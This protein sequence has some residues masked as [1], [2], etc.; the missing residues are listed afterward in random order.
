M[1]DWDSTFNYTEALKIAD[2]YVAQKYDN[3]IKSIRSM[4]PAHVEILSG[5][6]ADLEKQKVY[7]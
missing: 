3:E 2:G 7:K 4:N 5:Q 1:A 6:L